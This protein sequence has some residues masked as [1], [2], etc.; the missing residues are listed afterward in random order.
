MYTVA[1]L[2][3]LSTKEAL[4]YVCNKPTEPLA[5]EE[6]G[7]FENVDLVRSS[8]TI[9]R[10]IIANP[11]EFFARPDVARQYGVNVGGIDPETPL[12]ELA[13]MLPVIYIADIHNEYGTLGYTLNR[14]TGLT[15]KD[16][17]P[18]YKT[19]RMRNIYEGGTGKKGSS[20]TMLHQI[21]GFPENRPFKQL[22]KDGIKLFF[23][24]D[25]AMA[26]EMCLTDDAKPFDF[27]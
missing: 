8:P 25:I 10:Y 5:I 14:K 24:P 18:V 11:K 26:N 3:T 12:S 7:A 13:T 23:S 15:M 20:F 16:A 21:G 6:L 1:D 9:N 4:R 27:K 22:P 17:Y 19:F 2:P